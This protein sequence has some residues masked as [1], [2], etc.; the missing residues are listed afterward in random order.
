[1]ERQSAKAAVGGKL[2]GFWRKDFEDE[3]EKTLKFR[4]G[5]ISSIRKRLTL[6]DYNTLEQ[7]INAAEH[8][9]KDLLLES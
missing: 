4:T 7:W 3:E 5:L 6:G 1:M 9:E 2:S 8:A